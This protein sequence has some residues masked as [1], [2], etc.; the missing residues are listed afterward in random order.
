M[1][2]PSDG[3][4]PRSL[5]ADFIFLRLQKN[6]MKKQF[7]ILT[8]SLLCLG[9]FAQTKK[10]PVAPAGGVKA[11]SLKNQTDSLSYSIGT[12]VA[13]F[14]KQQGITKINDTMVTQAIRDVMNGR[15]TLLSEQQCNQVV[16]NYVEKVKAEK[17][18]VAKN[19]VLIF[20]RKIKLN[21]A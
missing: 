17:A 18:S 14:N 7:L 5:P 12:M 10:K 16:M 2:S 4:K 15:P 9:L 6:S 13:N 3:Q 11:V 1:L 20:W 19:K 8:L 21:L